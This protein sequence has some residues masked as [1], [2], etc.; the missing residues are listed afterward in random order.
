MPRQTPIQ[1]EGR[2]LQIWQ[3][4]AKELLEATRR[5]EEELRQREAVL[6]E[7]LLG[8]RGKHT[9]GHEHPL[10]SYSWCEQKGFEEFWDV[11][12]HSQILV[13]AIVNAII[14]IW[15]EVTSSMATPIW[16]V[17]QCL[18][19]WR[20]FE[21]PFYFSDHMF[22]NRPAQ[23]NSTGGFRCRKRKAA[24]RLQVLGHHSSQRWIA[25]S[26]AV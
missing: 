9:A 4:A 17:I 26:S 7:I 25:D 1:P 16:A 2:M 22:C 20:L 13:C 21:M 8:E 6:E 10:T 12:S 3:A 14:I 19:Y 18:H 15:A 23:H 24:G 5:H 11:L